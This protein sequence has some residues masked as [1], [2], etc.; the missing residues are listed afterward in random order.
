MQ[1]VF[2]MHTSRTLITALLPA[3]LLCTALRAQTKKAVKTD[4]VKT[5]PVEVIVVDSKNQPRKGEQIIFQSQKTK[6]VFTGRTDDA[7]KFSLMLPAGQDYTVKI[8]SLTD[9]SQYGNLSVPTLADDQYFT[10]AL[11]VDIEYEPARLYTLNDVHFDVG[12]ATIQ[13][14]SY[15]QLQEL[16]DYLQWKDSVKI[17]IAG[18]T[19][20][21]GNDNDN[22]KLSFQRAEAVKA[23]LIKKG[24][25]PGRL[26]ANGYGASQPVAD[27]ATE[28]GRRK[29]RRTE[30]RI[31]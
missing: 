31:L 15:K 6:K 2:Y 23:W 21:A 30:V 29:N 18:H 5:A 11:G 16:Y 9:T 27:N 20:N 7:G 8:K 4:T 22:L 1:K 17:E 10:K 24:I 3:L 26:T 28:E 13:P 14:A 19:D 25:Q 12:K